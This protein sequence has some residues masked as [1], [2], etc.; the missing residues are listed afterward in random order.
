MKVKCPNCHVP[1]RIT[2]D[3][4]LVEHVTKFSAP[5]RMVGKKL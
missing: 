5:C 2:R 4:V 1:V 3:G